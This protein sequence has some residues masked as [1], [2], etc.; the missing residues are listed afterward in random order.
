MA[1]PQSNFLFFSFFHL[2]PRV[3]TL[4]VHRLGFFYSVATFEMLRTE[5][6]LSLAL[7][8]L[9]DGW[10]INDVKFVEV[11]WPLRQSDFQEEA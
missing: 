5:V 8:V 7:N 11:R 10:I 4:E 6:L 3:L 1:L 9:S 2:V